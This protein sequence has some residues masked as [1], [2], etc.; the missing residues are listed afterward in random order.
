MDKA[1]CVR[2]SIIEYIGE[3]I[4][5]LEKKE[6]SQKIFD[7]YKNAVNEFY[8]NKEMISSAIPSSI[9]TIKNKYDKKDEKEKKENINYYFTYNFPAIL[10]CYGK[11]FWPKLSPLFTNLC[12]EKDIK[13]RRSII[14]SFHEVSKIV[15]EKITEEE[16]LSLYD[17][18]L[19]NKNTLEKNFAIKNLPK[20]LSNVNKGIKE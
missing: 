15:G 16:L 9:N 13:V 5:P 11:D 2:D 17:N 3:I 18:F 10:Y 12:R 8:Y 1:K 19:K 4:N 7:F 20:I 6:L 14:A